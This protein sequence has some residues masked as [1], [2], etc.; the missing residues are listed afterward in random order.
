MNCQEIR[1]H[2]SKALKIVG[3]SKV[4]PKHNVYQI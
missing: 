1:K 3:V 2:L 4:T